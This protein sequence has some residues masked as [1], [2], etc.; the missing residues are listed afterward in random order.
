MHVKFMHCYQYPATSGDIIKNVRSTKKPSKT[1]YF[2][3]VSVWRFRY[4]IERII[5]K[6]KRSYLESRK[7]V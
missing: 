5:F 4:V 6:A 3:N 2:L 7:N 1:A